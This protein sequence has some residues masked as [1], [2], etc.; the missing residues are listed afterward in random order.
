MS[1]DPPL[2]SSRTEIGARL[3]GE[4]RALR[5]ALTH[6]TGR[7]V[8]ARVDLDDLLQEVYLRALANPGGLPAAEEGDGSLRRYLTR[9]ARNVVVDA[10]RAIRAAK[11]DRPE[12]RIDRSHWSRVGAGSLAAPSPGPA[13][14]AASAEGIRRLVEA[15]ESLSPEHRR[16]IGLRQFEGLSARETAARMGRGE[17]AIHSLYRRA[18]AAWEA[19]T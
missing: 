16:V 15:F 1:E 4:E 7:A 17:V 14:D 10:A 2:P 6:L 8:R 5:L 9:I 19:A 3:A 13:T 18:L 11:R 12:A